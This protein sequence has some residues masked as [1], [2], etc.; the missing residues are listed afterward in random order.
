L[1]ELE[2][3]PYEGEGQP[4]ALKYELSGFWSR[5]INLEDR[6]I[7]YVEEDIVTVFIVSAIGHYE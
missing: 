7:Y 5:Q 1:A 3:T 6:L 4:E 2:E